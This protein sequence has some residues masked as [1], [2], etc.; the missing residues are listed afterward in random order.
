MAS[1]Q[2]WAAAVA[3]DQDAILVGDQKSGDHQDCQDDGE[4]RNTGSAQ[5]P[6]GG[7]KGDGDD[8]LGQRP[9]E[10]GVV[11]AASGV[12]GEGHLC[13]GNRH[14]E[15]GEQDGT[16]GVAAGQGGEQQ[17]QAERVEQQ[18]V[19]GMPGKCRN[20]GR[21]GFEGAVRQMGIV[22]LPAFHVEPAE[23]GAAVGGGGQ[24]AALAGQFAGVPGGVAAEGGQRFFDVVD[25]QGQGAE[26]EGQDGNGHP[27]EG[28]HTNN[29][30]RKN[31]HQGER[32]SP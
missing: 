32:N 28:R 12:G 21:C 24:K 16:Q 31:Q 15:Q 18:G 26:G 17:R 13:P 25:D 19:A 20:P 14:G 9:E 3:Q 11:H 2:F 1:V 27:A 4:C 29:L 22:G 8:H 6:G 7:G 30:F 5:A 10:D 23:E